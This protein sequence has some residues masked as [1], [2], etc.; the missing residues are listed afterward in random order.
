[1]IPNFGSSARTAGKSWWSK[2]IQLQ[3][4]KIQMNSLSIEN[5]MIL[6][7]MHTNS[8][9]STNKI[10]VN[11]Q[12]RCALELNLTKISEKLEIGT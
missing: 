4:T 3:P 11:E 10:L 7:H 8:L 5:L 12:F 6:L 1:M 2:A 9:D